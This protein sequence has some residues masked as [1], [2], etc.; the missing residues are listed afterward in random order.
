MIII[1]FAND[2]NVMVH[3]VV[4]CHCRVNFTLTH[5]FNFDVTFLSIFEYLEDAD[6]DFLVP[7]CTFPASLLYF[8]AAYK[9]I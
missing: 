2:V 7:C 4:A 1:T 5:I 9:S 6:T 3:G 8:R